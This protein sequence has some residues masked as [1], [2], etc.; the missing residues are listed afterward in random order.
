MDNYTRILKE[1]S[2]YA[3][4]S[5]VAARI[6]H[7]GK[8]LYRGAVGY[9]DIESGRLM[10]CNT[11]FRIF[12]MTKMIVGVAALKLFEQG[13]FQLDDPV[14]A[15]IPAFRDTQVL[16]YQLS[17]KPI[18]RQ[19]NNQVTMRNLF[20]MTAGFAYPGIATKAAT[21]RRH[22]DGAQFSAKVFECCRQD[23]LESGVPLTTRKVAD[24]L[25]TIPMCFEP[26]EGW[27]YGLCADILGA[28]VS[29]ISG[30]PLG[31][32]IDEVICGP[33]GM[34]DTTFHPTREQLGRSATIYNCTD[35]RH[36][37]PAPFTNPVSS[38][39]G[40]AT[41]ELEIC[42]G[43]MYST[44]D[45]FSRF[46]QM[47][48]NGGTLDGVRVLGRKT[49]ELMATDHLNAV[50]HEQFRETW[51]PTDFCSWGLMTRVSTSLNQSRLM[52]FPGSFGWAGAAGT[53]AC[54][55]PKEHLALSFMTQRMPSTSY[56][57]ITK[58]MQVAYGE[59]D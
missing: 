28:V 39:K 41:N 16:T 57:A 3:G 11:V 2:D 48:A 44:M 21:P 52:L 24:Y 43:G 8:D 7:K 5:G 12:S 20:T 27:I 53:I 4:G 30:K 42:I 45:D 35:P 38:I 15:F 40:C 6:T 26:G 55:D 9:A 36:P 1:F 17:D 19:S 51:Y 59:I 23:E 56:A 13:Y 33:L 58:L 49:V 25:A 14:S 29:E 32:Y 31:K 18:P 10:E 22:L 34:K 47:L 37:V 46:M 54:A 50:Q